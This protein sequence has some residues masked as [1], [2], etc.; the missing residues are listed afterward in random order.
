MPLYSYR[1]PDG[2]EV[3]VFHKAD[4]RPE[5]KCP[6]CGQPAERIITPPMVHTQYYFSTQIKS[7]RR[8]KWE[9]PPG[10]DGGQ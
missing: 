2:D 4:E 9:P 8:P 10:R 7:Q 5:V 3:E 1:C 6:S